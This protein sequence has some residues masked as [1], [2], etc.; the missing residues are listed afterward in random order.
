MKQKVILPQAFNTE[1]RLSSTDISDMV[2]EVIRCEVNTQICS[3]DVELTVDG[4]C[5]DGDDS[6]EDAA[7]SIDNFLINSH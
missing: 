6:G 3:H 2:A 5:D 7:I 1:I 4:I